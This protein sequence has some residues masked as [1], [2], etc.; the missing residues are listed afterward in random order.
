MY[1]PY[2]RA[3]P[4]PRQVIG[5]P[6]NRHHSAWIRR[7]MLSSRPAQAWSRPS[8]PTGARSGQAPAS[9]PAST[10]AAATVAAF[11]QRVA[12]SGLDVELSELARLI[13]EK[14]KPG[15]ERH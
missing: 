1:F 11:G 10:I 4:A 8:G 9:G 12:E 13:H 15:G 5:A 7:S 6:V 3:F 14:L 2:S